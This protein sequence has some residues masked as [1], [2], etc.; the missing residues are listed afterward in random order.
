V[1]WLRDTMLADGKV[2][3][4]DIDMLHVT[5]DID[6]AVAYFAAAKDS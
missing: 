2:G 1:D 6:E 3:A 5:D 4:A